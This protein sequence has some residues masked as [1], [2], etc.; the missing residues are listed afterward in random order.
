MF[1]FVCIMGLALTVPISFAKKEPNKW[2]A[3]DSTRNIKNPI[4]LT[5][6]VVSQGK[7][8]FTQQ[9]AACHGNSGKGDG[10]AAKYLGTKLP[11]FT[12]PSMWDQT[13]GEL[14]WKISNGKGTMP[15]FKG[16]LTEEQR[17][18]VVNYIRSLSPRK[19]K[20]EIV[21]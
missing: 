13:D 5:K 12:D 15:T 1:V 16:V 10:P 4:G 20:E 18:Q 14:F 9:C 21:P 6:P 7:K 8:I 11:D 2:T 3:P 19:N 17:W